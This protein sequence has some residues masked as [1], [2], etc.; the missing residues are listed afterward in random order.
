MGGGGRQRDPGCPHILLPLALSDSRARRVRA[1][2]S[3]LLGCSASRPSFSLGSCVCSP[4]PL[5]KP[6]VKKPTTGSTIGFSFS[7][8]TVSLSACPSVRP[9]GRTGNPGQ[10]RRTRR[11]GDLETPLWLS[12]SRSL[13]GGRGPRF[14]LVLLS[15]RFLSKGSSPHLGPAYLRP[16][17]APPGP[18]SL[19]PAPRLPGVGLTR[20]LASLPWAP[21]TPPPPPEFGLS[22]EGSEQAEEPAGFSC[23]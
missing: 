8:A 12:S 9:S 11:D 20:T 13:S 23:C 5:R 17:V 6:T 7:T 2:E 22:L 18:V 14:R 10:A 15:E 1:R 21:P 4:L 16:G 19:Y 3:C